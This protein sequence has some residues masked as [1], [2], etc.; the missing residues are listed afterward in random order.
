MYSKLFPVSP[1]VSYEAENMYITKLSI[2]YSCISL[3]AGKLTHSKWN[4]S[5]KSVSELNKQNN[6]EYIQNILTQ[7]QKNSTKT[8]FKNFKTVYFT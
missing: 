5:G 3:Q 4:G 8:Q 1:V 6:A 7:S 2:R